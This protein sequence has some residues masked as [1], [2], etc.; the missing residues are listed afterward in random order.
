MASVSTYLNFEASTERAFEFYKSVFGTEYAG[1]IHRIK[2]LPPKPGQTLTEEQGNRIMHMALPILGGHLLMGTDVPKVTA[3]DNVQIF[4]APDTRAQAE[5][6]FAA[7]AKG[8]KVVMPLEDQF[9]GAYFGQ[10]VDPF[11]VQW[12][13]NV[14]RAPKAGAA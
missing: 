5:Q 2:D 10:L 12:L 8:G 13:V 4:I 6:L 3:G 9:W 11:G 14:D 1:P 7:L